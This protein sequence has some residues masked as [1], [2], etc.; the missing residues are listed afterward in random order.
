MGVHELERHGSIQATVMGPVDGGHAAARKTVDDLV[1]RVDQPTNE[2]IRDHE[3]DST[4]P[5]ADRQPLADMSGWRRPTWQ[6][7]PVSP[8]V[9][10]VPARQQVRQVRQVV[11]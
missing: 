6:A 2:G 11:Q 9:S 4:V 1:A 10:G 3:R 5:E 8:A 7:P